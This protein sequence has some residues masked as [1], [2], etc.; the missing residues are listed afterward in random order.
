MSLRPAW[1]TEQVPGHLGYRLRPCQKFKN[2]KE[3][4][5][6]E[7]EEEGEGKGAGAAVLF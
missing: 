7:E 1:R 6:E 3:E 4:E 2:E 5:Q